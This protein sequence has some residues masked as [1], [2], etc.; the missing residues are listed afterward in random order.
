MLS[1]TSAAAFILCLANIVNCAEPPERI[2]IKLDVSGDTGG[3]VTSYLSRELRHFPDVELVN[4]DAHFRIEIVALELKRGA[5][6]T[7]GHGFSVVV[8]RPFYTSN[9]RSWIAGHLDA[10]T[11]KMLD[12]SAE[13]AVYTEAHFLEVGPNVQESCRTIV[14]S[15][16]G[17][18][19][20][21]ERKLNLQLD[22]MFKKSRA[23]PSPSAR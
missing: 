3:E 9:I 7:T 16:D 4:T 12:Q 17:S 1:L 19:F 13:K 21:P 15:I 18:V 11:L 23:T 8:T 22:E 10:G 5:G 2:R 14:A 20:E 6:V